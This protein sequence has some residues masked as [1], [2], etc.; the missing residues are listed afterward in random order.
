M[1]NKRGMSPLLLTIILI[2]FAVALGAMI[3]SWGA[4]RASTQSGSCQ[5]S[6][7][8][9]QTAFNKEMFCYNQATNKLKLVVK[10]SGKQKIEELIFRRISADLSVR[11]ISLPSS[12]MEPGRLYEAEIPYEPTAKTHIEL[13]PK[14]LVDNAPVLCDDKAIIREQITNCSTE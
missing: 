6:N 12:M 11:D 13:V 5:N 4:D 14:I 8:V 7:I 10:N 1:M 3:M 9:V 2:A